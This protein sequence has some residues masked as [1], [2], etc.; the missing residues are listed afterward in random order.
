ALFPDRRD[1]VSLIPLP[2][3]SRTIFLA[4]VAA[5]GIFLL[6]FTAAVNSV[7]TIMFPVIS[8][9]G[10]L[11]GLFNAIWAHA[12]SVFAGTAFVFVSLIAL[13]GILLNVL[14]VRWF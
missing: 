14:S 12:V 10:S 5:L 11:Y 2:I 7:S 6:T 4:K 13:E 3:R 8:F 1:Y 9:R